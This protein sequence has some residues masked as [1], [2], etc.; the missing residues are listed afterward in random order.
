MEVSG[1]LHD[2]AA[3]PLAKEPRY[4]SDMRLDGPQTRSEGYREEKNLAFVR[5]RTPDIQPVA[6]RYT[7]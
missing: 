4:L 1:K 6:H 2:P 7:D 5:N 3:L